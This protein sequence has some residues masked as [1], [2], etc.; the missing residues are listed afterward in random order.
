M[1]LANVKIEK[2]LSFSFYT[3]V[4]QS[5]DNLN[6]FF[7]LIF[8]KNT[9]IKKKIHYKVKLIYLYIY[10]YHLAATLSAEIALY[11]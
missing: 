10:D 1:K 11:K 9:T 2:M 8:V 6:F 7:T 3:F 4:C 5:T